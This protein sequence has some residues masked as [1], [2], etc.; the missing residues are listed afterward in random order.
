M[1]H[2][3]HAEGCQRAVPRKM[4]MCGTHWR[5]VPR[6]LQDDVWDTYVSGQEERMDPTPAYLYAANAAVEAVAR[7][8]GRR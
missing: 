4:L 7:K 5:M 8:E 1:A 2:T 3:C 6:P